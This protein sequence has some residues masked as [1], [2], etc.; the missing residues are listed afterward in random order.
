LGGRGGGERH[1]NGE[2][3]KERIFSVLKVP[4]QF[5]VVLLVGARLLF[6]INSKF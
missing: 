4:R 5:P 2:G 3:V 6:R 1:Y